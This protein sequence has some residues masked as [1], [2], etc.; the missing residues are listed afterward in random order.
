MTSAD[1]PEVRLIASLISIC[2]KASMRPPPAVVSGDILI[3]DQQQTRWMEA[4][5]KKHVCRHQAGSDVVF[6]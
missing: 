6:F 1:G 2:D 5:Q 3:I 4:G